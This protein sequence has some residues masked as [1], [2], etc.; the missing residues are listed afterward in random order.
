M[1]MPPR[2]HDERSPSRKGEAQDERRGTHVVVI[3]VG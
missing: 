3:D 2:D 1:P